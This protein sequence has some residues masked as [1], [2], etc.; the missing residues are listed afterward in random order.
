MKNMVY[1]CCQLRETELNVTFTAI[2]ATYYL[3]TAC[4]MAE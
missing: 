3:T 1:N 4:K 2:K